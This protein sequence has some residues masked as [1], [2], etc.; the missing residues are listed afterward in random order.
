MDAGIFRLLRAPMSGATFGT[1]W[2]GPLLKISNSDRRAIGLHEIVLFN[3]GRAW[4]DLNM[5]Y[6][7]ENG[8][9]DRSRALQLVA[10]CLDPVARSVQKFLVTRLEPFDISP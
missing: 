8:I 6:L 9:T 5:M 4:K 7:K 1:S 3:G 2:S 10:S